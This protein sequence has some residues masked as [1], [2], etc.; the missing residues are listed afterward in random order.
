ML[1]RG[2][3]GRGHGRNQVCPIRFEFGGPQYGLGKSVSTELNT[4]VLGNWSRRRKRALL[5]GA[6]ALSVAAAIAFGTAPAVAKSPF[7]PRQARAQNVNKE[8]FGDISKGPLQIFVSLNNEQLHLYSDGALVASAPVST[9]VPGH[10]TPLGVFDVIQRD[11]FHHSNIYS[12]AP[13]PFMQR[14]T[15]SGVALHEGEGVGHPASHGCIRMPHQFA[16]RLWMMQTLGMRV[17]IT[18]SAL[19]PADFADSHLFVRKT[20]AEVS[21]ATPPVKTAQSLDSNKTTDANTSSM[22][23]L[24]A[25]PPLV[26]SA[27]LLA[28]PA[29]WGAGPIAAV[30]TESTTSA[31]VPASA[32]TPVVDQATSSPAAESSKSAPTM[33]A[34][35]SATSAPAAAQ[36]SPDTLRGTDATQ[37][38]PLVAPG[39]AI[40]LPSA[41]PPALAETAA[42][43]H[44]PISIFVSRKTMRIYVRQ[45]F[46]PLFDAPITI[47]NPDQ[48]IGTHVFTAMDYLTDGATFRWNVVSMPGEARKIVRVM[49]RDRR[50]D[51]YGR[52]RRI[53]RTEQVLEPA[54]PPE[55]PQQA[56]ARIEIPQDVIDRISELMVPGS[57]LIV[58]DQGLGPETGLGTDFIVVTR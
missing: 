42:A 31:D 51:G 24:T 34:V 37:A 22:K 10:P 12:N 5:S 43:S 30:A 53:E 17:I 32:A 18:R 27:G 45:H 29:P 48:A 8:P 20:E 15:W 41:K 50:F 38:V 6:G 3:L 35:D 25:D 56:L 9:G 47:A 55:T 39:E 1:I 26:P 11:R 40:P 23:A 4:K 44:R 21:A 13:M 52:A 36:T 16:A 57:S 46:A 54:P 14:I 49:E 2:N 19:A 28:A 33:P 7:K 58:S